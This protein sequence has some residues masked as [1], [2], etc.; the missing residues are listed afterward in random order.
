MKWV[1]AHPCRSAKPDGSTLWHGFITDIS[2]RKRSEAKIYELAYFDP[3]TSLPNRTMLRETAAA[4]DRRGRRARAPR[5]AALRRPR[6]FQD[7][8][9]HQGPSRRR[10][11]AVRDG[12][13]ASAPASA[14]GDLV[15]RL[16]GDE[17]VVLLAG[18]ERQR[19]RRRGASVEAHRR[20]R[21]CS[22][23]PALPARRSPVPHDGEH[24]HRHLPR[25]RPRRR[26]RAEAR[27]PRHVR[28]E[29][30]RSRDAALLPERHAG[31][32]RRPR[33]R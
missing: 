33:W 31:R 22:D 8:E 7:A 5:R 18:T 12:A 4:G 2:E 29:G 17:F 13:S 26:R 23:R 9:R 10:P 16:G 21:P 32:R 19:R 1:F 27:R 14:P 20:E 30:R 3:L 6:P 11:A 24:R 28:G 25:R 15:A